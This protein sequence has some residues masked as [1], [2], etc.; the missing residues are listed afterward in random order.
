L[1]IAQAGEAAMHLP[2]IDVRDE[3]ACYHA[4]VQLLHP[5][6]LCCPGCGSLT[7]WRIHRSQRAPVVDSLCL[8]C[9][10]VFNAWTGTVLR[11]TRLPPTVLWRLVLAIE[12]RESPAAVAREVGRPRASLTN[13]YHRLQVFLRTSAVMHAYSDYSI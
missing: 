6:G 12:N 8:H 9:H 5:Q 2:A 10:H 7:G 11:R 3:T 1:D 4:L 13:W